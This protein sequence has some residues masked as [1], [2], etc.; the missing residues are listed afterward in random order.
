MSSHIDLGTQPLRAGRAR[1]LQSIGHL[2]STHWNNQR[3]HSSGGGEIALRNKGE[4]ALNTKAKT[5][6]IEITRPTNCTHEPIIT[7]PATK[8]GIKAVGLLSVDLEDQAGIIADA[9]PK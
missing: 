4:E 7:S 3:P 5:T 2:A 9:T 8:L 1:H 6:G